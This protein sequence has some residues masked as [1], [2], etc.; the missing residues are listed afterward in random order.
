MM[1]ELGVSGQGYSRSRGQALPAPAAAS[2][3]GMDCSDQAGSSV[4]FCKGSMGSLRLPISEGGR[5]DGG[6]GGGPSSGGIS[7][8]DKLP[9]AASA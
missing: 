2:A 3:D 1:G 7:E 6:R 5:N 4:R 8:S 9:R